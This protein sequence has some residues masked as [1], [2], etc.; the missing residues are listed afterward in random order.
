MVLRL[1]LKGPRSTCCLIP[2][3]VRQP[4]PF[5]NAADMEPQFAMQQCDRSHTDAGSRPTFPSLRPGAVLQAGCHAFVARPPG[6]TF[7]DHTGL[8]WRSA[9]QQKKKWNRWETPTKSTPSVTRRCRPA[10]L[11]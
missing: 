4:R 2:A 9:N 6:L 7:A 5:L 8:V 11:T 10:R 3:R 1:I